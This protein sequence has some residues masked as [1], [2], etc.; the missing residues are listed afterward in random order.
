VNWEE[1][2]MSIKATVE[3]LARRVKRPIYYASSAGRNAAHE[4][5]QP[6]SLVDVD[7]D[8]ARSG[9]DANTP[10]EF[11]MHPCGF[12]LHELP[13]R[14]KDFLDQQQVASVYEAEIESFL[15]TITGCYRVHIFDHTVRASDPG[16]RELKQ[17]REPASLVHNDYTANSGFT[18]LR[19]NL[20]E[21]APMLA[22]GRFQIVNIWRPL[23]DP[24]EDYPLAL[25][26][27]RSVDPL[28]LIDSERRAANHR[29]E[30]QLAVHAPQ[31]HWYYYPQMR[32]PEVLLFKTFDSKDGGVN[33]CSIHS[34]IRLPGVRVDARP[35]ESIETRAFVF[36]R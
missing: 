28:D 32:P 18:C 5:D 35:R 36:Y 11:G 33:P 8:D 21:D 31:Q 10:G 13:T 12:D 27:A 14:V 23:V 20:G 2:E 4:I 34:A 30:I 25:C 26:D 24:V 16:L 9:L 1:I 6:M 17:I 3:Y 15:R 29:G 7:V 19:E 22:R